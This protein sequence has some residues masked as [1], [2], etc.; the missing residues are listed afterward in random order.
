[1]LVRISCK[2]ALWRGYHKGTWVMEHSSFV[3]MKIYAEFYQDRIDKGD[4][5]R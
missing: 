5:N 1:M 4:A 3:D 2:P